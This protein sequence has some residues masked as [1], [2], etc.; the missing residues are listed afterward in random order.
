MKE[1]SEMLV[2]TPHTPDCTRLCN[3]VIYCLTVWAIT[4]SVVLAARYSYRA[5]PRRR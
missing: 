2:E 3:G 5:Q 1:G 4:N